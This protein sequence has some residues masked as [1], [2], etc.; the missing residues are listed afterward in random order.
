ML[1]CVFHPTL[2][3]TVEMLTPKLTTGEQESAFDDD[4][5]EGIFDVIKAGVSLAGQGVAA[6]AHHGLPILAGILAHAGGT[7]ALETGNAET[8]FRGPL[9]Q[10]ALVADAA[11]STVLQVQRDQLQEAG[12]FD[13]LT[14][15]VKVIAP[16]VIKAAPIVAQNVLPLVKK[17]VSGGGEDAFI[18]AKKPIVFGFYPKETTPK[19]EQPNEGV[20]FSFDKTDAEQSVRE[21]LENRQSNELLFVQVDSKTGAQTGSTS[22]TGSKPQTNS[23]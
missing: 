7:E 22:S 1:R 14:K 12:F 21:P 6:V 8:S 2:H 4:S 13:A 16:V 17:I 10:R 20:K 19:N 9:A 15:A 3:T 23:V 5:Q 11:L 18:P